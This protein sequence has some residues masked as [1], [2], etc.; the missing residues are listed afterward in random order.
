MKAKVIVALL[1]IPGVAVC[2]PYSHAELRPPA[3]RLANFHD[4][5]PIEDVTKALSNQTALAKVR[6]AATLQDLSGVK[7]ISDHVISPSG[8]HVLY[9]LDEVDTE[10][11]TL[12]NSLWKL[13]TNGGP[14]VKLNSGVSQPRWSPDE[15]KIAFLSREGGFQIW[16][17][18]SNGSDSQKLTS[19]DGGVWTFEWSPDSKKIAFVATDPATALRQEPT[20]VDENTAKTQLYII[21]VETKSTKQISKGDR[22]VAIAF[23]GSSLSWSPDGKE[24]AFALEFATG[25]EASY[26]TDLYAVSLETDRARPLVERAGMDHRPTWSTDGSQIAFLSSYG[27]VN[28]LANCGLS[29]VSAQ[30]GK[31]RDVGQSFAGGFF[32]FGPFDWSA[33]SKSLYF[34]AVKGATTQLFVLPLE[35]GKMVQVT[36]AAK[37][38][39]GFSFSKDKKMI[40]FRASD[41]KQPA[42]LYFSRLDKFSP[43]QLTDTNPQ[44]KELSLGEVELIRWSNGKGMEIEGLLLKPVGY[45]P[46]KRYPLLTFAHAGPDLRVELSYDLSWFGTFRSGPNVFQYFASQGYAVFLPNFRG[47]SGYGESFRRALYKDFG[48][49]VLDDIL[50]GVEFLVARGIVDEDKLGIFGWSYGGYQAA[51]AITQTNRFKAAVVGAAPVSLTVMYGEGSLPVWVESFMGGPPWRAGEEYERQSPLNFAH[52]ATTP[53]LILH[54]QADN[55]VSAVQSR[56]FHTHLKRNN[57]PTQLVIYPRQGHSIF[58]LKLQ[59]DLAQRTL[60]WFDGLLGGKVRIP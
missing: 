10:R 57:V 59:L 37:V 49:P 35:T 56:A 5:H 55:N 50:T 54:G 11:N 24:I 36:T 16:L 58:E 3:K 31:P 43:V 41:P 17:T 26:Y 20:V 30:G 18:D 38:H 4:A 52:R 33:D 44:L 8:L 1:L 14:G 60:R 21:D 27:Q 47:S 12:S 15:K 25:F 22:S 48:K 51:W 29:V 39:T 42:E 46:N 19:V 32:D 45:E 23:G 34:E 40:A 6:R 13:P 9:I 7:R 53:T 28:R 2:A